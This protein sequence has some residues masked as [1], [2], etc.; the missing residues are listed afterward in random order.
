[1]KKIIL[2]TIVVFA[3]LQSNAQTNSYNINSKKVLF[4]VN[5]YSYTEGH[6]NKEL[7]FIEFIL[8]NKLSAIER[9]EGLREI[10]K[11]FKVNPAY[12]LKEI[13]QVDA[14]MQQ[15]YQI[16]DVAMIGRMRSALI[17]QIYAGAQNLQ[18]QE[19]PFLVKL[20]YKY[21]PVLAFDPQNMLAFTYRDF[22]AYIYL[23]QFNAQMLGQNVQFTQQQ[24]IETQN[25][26]VQQ[27]NYMTVEQKQNL[28]SMQV[29]YDY[30][31]NVYN[32]MTLQQR[33]QWQ[34][35]MLN[36]QAYQYQNYNSADAAFEQGY[37]QAQQNNSYDVK[38][39]DGIN[40]KAEK[41]AYLRQMQNN[42]NSNSAAMDIYYNTMMETHTTMLNTIE[43]FGDTGVYW[44][45]K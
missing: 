37:N 36:Q 24:I 5:G 4:N 14:Q 13:E 19:L 45:Y 27:F 8:G 25:Y 44:E 16:T 12:T 34:N 6:F 11:N 15:M 35:Q 32:Q 21:V 40:T 33:Q 20:M 26:L 22:E 38:W 30:I 41:Q 7:R 10:E 23:M 29:Q 1:M 9:Q 17:S 39:P 42:M 3:F 18:G 43:N 2:S 28:C 31:S